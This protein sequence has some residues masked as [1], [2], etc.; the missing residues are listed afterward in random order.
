[1]PFG[2]FGLTASSALLT[3]RV[4]GAAFTL[5]ATALSVVP[6]GSAQTP[7]GYGDVDERERGFVEG[8][9]RE[10]PGEAD[11]Y[12]A[13]RDA[14]N[15]AVAEVQKVQA[16]YSAAGPELRPM[17]VKQLRE[18]ERVYAERSLALLDFLDARERRALSR[19]REE[20]DRIN[21]L[22]EERARSRGE[23]E[24]LRRGE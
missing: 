3:V 15:E 12:V 4:L 1:M 5:V 13:L 6:D 10:D 2:S 21:R 7:A 23:L 22:L 9:R 8:L 16:R 11:R 14:R 18:A 24:K 17:F 19:Y 20:I